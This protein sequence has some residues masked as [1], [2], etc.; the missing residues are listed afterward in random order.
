MKQASAKLTKQESRVTVAV[1]SNRAGIKKATVQYRRC[2][3][4]YA[5]SVREKKQID[6]K[7]RAILTLPSG[8]SIR[9][10]LDSQKIWAPLVVAVGQTGTRL[11]VVPGIL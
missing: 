8:V 4:A 1:D 9:A 3:L 7:R 11:T 2:L 10:S 6:K 5:K